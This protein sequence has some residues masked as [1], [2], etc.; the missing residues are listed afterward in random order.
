G[1]REVELWR[2]VGKASAVEDKTTIVTSTCSFARLS[3]IAAPS[4]DLLRTLLLPRFFHLL[5]HLRVTKAF[6]AIVENGSPRTPRSKICCPFVARF[7]LNPTAFA[8]ILLHTPASQ[9]I[10]SIFANT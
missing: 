5:F 4:Y 7:E 6:E 3:P 2:G 10:R 9:T 1:F 8:R